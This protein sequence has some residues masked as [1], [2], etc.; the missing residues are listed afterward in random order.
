M[1]FPIASA[2]AIAA[3]TASKQELKFKTDLDFRTRFER[4]LNKDFSDT[5]NDDQTAFHTRI[6]PGITA[7]Y[8]DWSL[9]AQHQFAHSLFWTNTKNFSSENSDI[10]ELY[11]RY[12]FDGNQS[13]TVGRQRFKVNRLI[14]SSSWS[15]VSST[16]Q[17]IR[18]N[19]PEWQAFYLGFEVTKSIP[20]DA[21]VVGIVNKNKLGSTSYILKTD[22]P[23]AGETTL[24]TLMHSWTG[25]LFGTKANFDIAGQVGKTAGKDHSAYAIHADFEI[26]TQGDFNV[27]LEANVASGGQSANH[28]RTFDDLYPSTHD[29][30]GYVDAVGWRNIQEIALKTNYSFSEK[31]SLDANI[32]AFWLFDAADGFYSGSSMNKGINGNLID[33]TGSSGKN[34]GT[35]FNLQLNHS[36][37]WADVALSY[38]V[39]TPGGFIKNQNGGSANPRTYWYLN[40]GYKF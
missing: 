7:T 19:S 5:V 21:R 20:N 16:F 18:Y 33:P 28:T 1:V 3:S 11:L 35:E 27:N 30:Y 29:E 8:G 12:N 25:Q 4:T 24:H 38:N 2:L 13:L 26:P 6:K 39:F 22:N 34:L 17:G 31:T 32:H 36:M 40:V 14:A 10:I 15:N 37:G 9:R 23:T